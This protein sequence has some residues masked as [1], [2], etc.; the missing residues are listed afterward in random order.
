MIGVYQYAITRAA[1]FNVHH[2]RSGYKKHTRRSWLL[3]YNGLNERCARVAQELM[4]HSEIGLTMKNYTDTN[5]LPIAS[6]VYDLSNLTAKTVPQ[7]VPPESKNGNFCCLG[8][9]GKVEG[10]DAEN[11]NNKGLGD[12]FCPLSLKGG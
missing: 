2:Q 1:T 11:P 8:E 6:A 3:H 7:A 12:M 5:L 9:S 10:S 4:R